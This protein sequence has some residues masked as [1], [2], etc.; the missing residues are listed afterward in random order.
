MGGA[1]S[2]VFFIPSPLN[3]QNRQYPVAPPFPRPPAIHSPKRS[4]KQKEALIKYNFENMKKHADQL[5]ELAQSLQKKI[6]ASNQDVLSVDV[7]RQAEQIEKLAKKIK[8][9]ARGY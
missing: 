8:N 2:L 6:N 9:E 7:V 4:E 5:A 3:A 1:L